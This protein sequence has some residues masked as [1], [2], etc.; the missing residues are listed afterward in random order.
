MDADPVSIDELIRDLA[1]PWLPEDVVSVNDAVVRL[2]RLEGVF[3]W[4][5]HDEDELFLCWDGEF[6]IELADDGPVMLRR[7]DVFVVPAGV[8]HRP[9]AD[10]VSHALLLERPETKQ[11]GS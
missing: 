3:P 9:V 4:H 7:G 10:V 5:H 11:Y 6:R 1:G 2:A 8:E